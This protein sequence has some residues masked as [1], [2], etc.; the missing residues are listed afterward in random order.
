MGILLLASRGGAGEDQG[1]KEGSFKATISADEYFTVKLV[2]DKQGDIRVQRAKFSLPGAYGGGVAFSEP[3]GK[4]QGGKL[5]FELPIT[6]GFRPAMPPSFRADPVYVYY[7]AQ[8]TPG[9]DGTLRCELSKIDALSDEYSHMYLSI[10]TVFDA[11]VHYSPDE[12][13]TEKSFF[14]TLKSEALPASQPPGTLPP[15]AKVIYMIPPQYKM[16]SAI[17]VLPDL[18]TFGF[19]G[20]T[21]AGGSA[22]YNGADVVTGLEE[23]GLGVAVEGAGILF[24]ASKSGGAIKILNDKVYPPEGARRLGNL[25]SV[26]VS[27][28]GQHIAYITQ[29]ND[30][31]HLWVDGK[32]VHKDSYIGVAYSPN[33]ALKITDEGIAFT[34]VGY[35]NEWRMLSGQTTGPQYSGVGEPEIT[36]D[37]KHLA[38]L[39]SKGKER[40]LVLDGVEVDASVPSD[41]NVV[42]SPDGK[43]F[44]YFVQRYPCVDGSNLV[45]LDRVW[46]DP[47]LI[48]SASKVVYGV[49]RAGKQS[50]VLGDQ[51]ENC[52]RFDDYVFPVT[53][54]DGKTVAWAGSRTQPAGSEGRTK[55]ELESFIFV[56]GQKQKAVGGVQGL[57]LDESGRLVAYA[58]EL[59]T[60]VRGNISQQQE[61]VINGKPGKLYDTVS[62]LMIGP[63]KSVVYIATLGDRSYVV[64]GTHESDPYD[65]V[66][67]PVIKD[68]NLVYAALLGRAMVSI[69]VQQ[70]IPN[71]P[72][73]TAVLVPLTFV[74]IPGALLLAPT[75]PAWNRRRKLRRAR[76]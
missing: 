62:N 40:V 36:P 74:A 69:T 68:G 18:K 37:G 39:A 56:N 22:N 1:F 35:G 13:T 25:N 51:K 47:A 15:G 73:K 43:Q 20:I 59:R 11:R 44:R 60:L 5:V 16:L 2:K 27:P 31:Y 24:S 72:M 55:P 53:T 17:E 76:E 65:K 29:E 63:D 52:E 48:A 64:V 14:L 41:A 38:Y 66:W 3:V 26:A 23:E 67:P 50:I 70:K 21:D 46:S 10:E 4:V 57:L 30:G 54:S 6:R 49:K 28:N 42:L 45:P 9:A 32:S 33:D 61:V 12:D 19:A 71:P 8:L 7:S 34:M 75:L 58:T